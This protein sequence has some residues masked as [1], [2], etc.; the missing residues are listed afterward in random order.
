[1]KKILAVFAVCF[2][3]F[4]FLSDVEANIDSKFMIGGV[5]PGMSF[6]E[7]KRILGE[8]VSRH[9][10]DEYIFANGI[11]IEVKEFN[12]IVEEI[13]VHQA[14]VS[15]GAGIAVGMSDQN[16][17]N[18]YGRA[19]SIDNDDGAVEYKYYSSDRMVK[20]EFEVRNGVI[21]SIKSKLND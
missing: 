20:I 15:T 18:A 19:D 9:D 1:M 17:N 10:K 6:D 16:L 12:N 21:S 8:P 5:A 7:A 2:G 3:I 11:K 14:G 13:K 4:L